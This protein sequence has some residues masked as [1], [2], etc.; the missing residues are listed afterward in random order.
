MKQLKDS[1]QLSLFFTL[2][3]MILFSANTHSQVQY[4]KTLQVK[5]YGQ[6][7][8]LTWSTFSE[9]NNSSFSIERSIDGK[10]YQTIGSINSK[11]E[12]E[13]NKYQFKD[14]ELGLKKVSYR[15]KS[16]LNDGEHSYSKVIS[17]EKKV[18]NYF[19]VTEKEQLPNNQY[20]IYI[21]SIKEG[22]LKCRFSTILGDVVYDE[23]KPLQ[24]GLNEF[25]FDLSNEPDGSY[26]IVFKMDRNQT[27][28]A[29]KKETKEKNNVAQSK[30]TTIK[31]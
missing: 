5:N 4:E 14:E 22:E 27:S 25:F 16:I 1:K 20:K 24:V 2:L 11:N 19:K 3:L 13:I 18:V 29:L 10:N 23:I 9:V 6:G 31:Y 28:V 15:L 30:S 12:K 8:I 26:N 7:F 21:N 17:S